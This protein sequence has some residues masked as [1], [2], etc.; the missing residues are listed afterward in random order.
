[1]LCE[2]CKKNDGL[3]VDGLCAQCADES[4]T[5]GADPPAG[6]PV[7]PP[8]AAA[9]GATYDPRAAWALLRS[10][11][12]LATVATVLLG[13]VVLADVG[14]VAA[15]IAEYRMVSALMDGTAVYDADASHTE[16]LYILAGRAQ[17][18]ALIVTAIG[19]I[20]W[21]LRVRDNAHVFAPQGQS[22]ARAW[23]IFGFLVPVVSLW[24]PRRIA[25]DSWHASAGGLE[26]DRGQ[27]T[28]MVVETWWFLFLGNML[29]GRLAG[30]MYSNAETLAEARTATGVVM[31]SDVLDIV[32]AGAAIV[33]VR[34]LTRL[35]NQKVTAAHPQV[36]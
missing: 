3:L 25:L 6:L 33:F 26:P 10:P 32:S 8:V 36:A 28:S 4:G 22:K 29:V 9:Q 1:M 24:F 31:F 16:D 18:G 5:L 23:A 21:F 13:L 27:S 20:A 17:T 19:F 11:N 34:S 12:G 30:S 2:R 7:A 35:Q 14:A 15:G